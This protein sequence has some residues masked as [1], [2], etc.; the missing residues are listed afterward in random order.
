MERLLIIGCGDIARRA[1]PALLA[2]YH[3]LALVRSHADAGQL[4][5]LGV[6]P[7]VGDLDE[8]SSLAPLAGAADRIICL[9]PP[10]DSGVIDSRTGNLLS[11]LRE[12]PSK[13]GAMLAHA[14]RRP[15]RC[16]YVS[17]SGVYGDCAGALVDET[18]AVN[19]G[20]QRAL[21][22]VD[23]ERAWTEFGRAT[24]AAVVILRVPGIYASDRL[25]LERIRRGTPV[26]REQ[27]DVFTNHIHADDLA[28]IVVAAIEHEDAQGVFNASDDSAL[29]MAQWFDLI[30]DR[31]GL[32]RPP[33]IARS[34]AAG[35]IAPALLSFMSES[36]R[37]LNTKMKRELRV[38]L[39]YPTVREGVPAAIA[40]TV[41]PPDSRPAVVPTP[42][43]P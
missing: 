34:E 22:R 28:A 10:P 21:R 40:V 12:P 26:L 1:L 9:A 11:V 43:T 33:R 37:L 6:E 15:R 20:T 41:D 13:S 7:I 19:P 23:A 4:A 25:P 2:R 31:A 24:R 17:T 38:Q 5:D 27:D 36:R 32:P 29:K 18:R 35:R 30:A 3:V 39:R 14:L 8:P 16:V 42:N